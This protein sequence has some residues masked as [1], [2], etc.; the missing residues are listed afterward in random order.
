MLSPSIY[1][2]KLWFI[3][4]NYVI[5]DKLFNI[6]KLENFIR[7]NNFWNIFNLKSR[8]FIVDL[9]INVYVFCFLYI[10]EKLLKFIVY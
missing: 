8:E 9:E 1:K 2:P 3:L 4:T 5:V 6:Y 10:F 7:L